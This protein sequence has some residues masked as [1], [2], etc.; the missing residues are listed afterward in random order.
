MAGSEPDEVPIWQRDCGIGVVDVERAVMR[1]FEKC[2]WVRK[3]RSVRGSFCVLV[4]DLRWRRRWKR[5]I[6]EVWVHLSRG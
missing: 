6:E 1:Y 2:R 4:E 5:P 3:V